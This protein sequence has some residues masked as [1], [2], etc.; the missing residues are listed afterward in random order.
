[1]KRTPTFE[2]LRQRRNAAPVPV[3]PDPSR[4]AHHGKWLVMPDMDEG[5]DS[6]YREV[7]ERIARGGRI[8]GH[9]L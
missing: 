7:I 1:V 9:A 5:P 3:S 2:K 6:A 8:R 4:S